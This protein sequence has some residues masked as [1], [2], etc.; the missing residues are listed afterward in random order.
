MRVV[1]CKDAFK[2]WKEWLAPWLVTLDQNLTEH[3]RCSHCSSKHGLELNIHTEFC[4]SK[5]KTNFNFQLYYFNVYRQY[6]TNT[7]TIAMT[8]SP[9]HRTSTFCVNMSPLKY[10]VSAG[11]R[12]FE[13][14]GSVSELPKHDCLFII[15]PQF[16]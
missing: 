12:L 6:T 15:K 16:K 8:L 4:D 13:V 2:G 5:F 7:S 9:D 1:I 10:P 11:H 14:S 3:S